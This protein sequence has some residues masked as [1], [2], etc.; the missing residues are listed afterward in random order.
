MRF[1]WVLCENEE[2]QMLFLFWN[3]PW[4]NPYQK[5]V[6]KDSAYFKVTRFRI[7]AV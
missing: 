1:N 4:R 6:H 7:V 5:K 2:I 3:I